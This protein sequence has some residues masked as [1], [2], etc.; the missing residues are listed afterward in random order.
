MEKVVFFFFNCQGIRVRGNFSCSPSDTCEEEVGQEQAERESHL[1]T[2]VPGGTISPCH[3]PSTEGRTQLW[4]G[5][6][7][8]LLGPP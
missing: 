2:C 7:L 8:S 3:S 4:E 6:T 1:G 5:Q